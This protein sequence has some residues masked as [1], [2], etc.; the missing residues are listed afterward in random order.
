VAKK[1]EPLAKDKMEKNMA[2]WYKEYKEIYIYILNIC[3]YYIFWPEFF[4]NLAYKELQRNTKKYPMPVDSL[5]I[6]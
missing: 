3:F 5:S 2:L 1:E 6:D 4:V